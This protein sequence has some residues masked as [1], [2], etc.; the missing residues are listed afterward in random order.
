[1][2]NGEEVEKATVELRGSWDDPDICLMNGAGSPRKRVCVGSISKIIYGDKE[3]WRGTNTWRVNQV[4][5]NF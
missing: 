3:T 4:R 1:M 2:Q 5:F